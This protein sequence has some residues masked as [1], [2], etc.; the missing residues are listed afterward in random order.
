MVILETIATDKNKFKGK[1]ALIVGTGPSAD[2][3]NEINT[4][5][6]VLIGINRVIVLSKSFNYLMTD[7][8]ETLSV[9]SK[10]LGNT[11]KICV[12]LYSRE[13]CNLN[14]QLIKENSEKI[15]LFS[16][17]YEDEGIFEAPE[18]SLNDILLYISW[19][20]TQ[21]ALHFANRL[22]CEKAVFIGVDGKPKDNQI[23]AKEIEKIFPI[24]RR[25]LIKTL[26]DY[27]KTRQGLLRIAE[28]L[29]MEISF[30]NE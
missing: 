24:N 1:T 28:K 9:V 3:L 5:D 19:G 29:N 18:Y 13:K 6:F 12:P 22:G 26:G 25:R 7:S 21:S 15:L 10:Y 23:N 14:H 30:Y 2:Y 4:E 8:P 20:T 16:W 11:N 27:K 17:V